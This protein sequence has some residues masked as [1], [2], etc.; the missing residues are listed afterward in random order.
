MNDTYYEQLVS[1]KSKPIDYVIRFL[2]IFVIIAI[3]F[4]GMP[5]I[6]FLAIFVAV[7][8]GFLAFYFVIPRL[9]VEYEYVLLNHD[10]DIDAIYSQAK[11]KRLFSFDIKEAEIVAPAN[12]PRLQSYTP[13]KT[14]NFS[15]GRQQA[16]TYAIMINRGEQL[17]R[18]LF[19]PD[20]T[21]LHHMSNWLGMKLYND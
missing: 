5:F 17:T 7:L 11:R 12:S 8:V 16:N 1:R 14:L 6:G 4:F 20:E 15:S 19:D 21:M 2:V 18:I 10:M 13:T 3:A 9:N